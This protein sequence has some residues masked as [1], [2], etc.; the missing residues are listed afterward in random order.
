ML[1]PTRTAKSPLMVPG[2]ES[3]G[4]VS[5]NMTR[6]VLTALSPLAAPE[7]VLSTG[8]SKLSTFQNFQDDSPDQTELPRGVRGLDQ[9]ADQHGVLR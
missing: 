2:L 1:R 7:W 5:P 8:R 9:Q 4:L 6:P 3:A